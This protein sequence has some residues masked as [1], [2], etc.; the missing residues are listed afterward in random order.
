MKIKE[1]IRE[2]ELVAPLSYQEDYDNSGLIVG[3]PEDEVSGVLLS[4]DTTEDVVEEA[5]RLGKNL[6][7]AHHPIIFKGLKK[8][9][10]KNYVERV[11][12]KAI[13]HNIAIYAAHTNLDNVLSNGVNRKFAEKLGLKDIS[14][15]Q[16][17]KDR[18]VKV[19][20]YTPLKDEERIKAALFA[21]GAGVIGDYS[22]CSFSIQGQGTFKPGEG[23]SPAIG[24]IG[25]REHVNEARVEVIAP[26][27]KASRIVEE[28]RTIHPYEEMAYDIFPLKNENQELGS[29]AY[30][31]LEKPMNAGE[32]LA[33]LKKNMKLS[34]VRH[35]YFEGQIHKVAVCGGVGSFL[36]QA[37][38]NI[39]AD[40]YV[41]ADLKYH[42]FFDAENRLLLCDIGHYESEISTLEIFYAV[43]K[44]KF[45]T[46]AVVFC[47]TSTNPIQ[48]YS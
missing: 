14:I 31:Y 5:I 40:A 38:L 4:L 17:K 26:E 12:I 2:I 41:T 13:R 20:I 9:N 35:T 33:L 48:Y 8:I 37:A 36:I 15:L 39:K 47:E 30:G 10:G 43:I 18:L 27:F 22:E 46:F 21:A 1:I 3:H 16:P 19:V 23:A 44:E 6:I 24:E 28:V 7:I 11:I 45:P 42:E 25:Q 29:G 32:F 34:L